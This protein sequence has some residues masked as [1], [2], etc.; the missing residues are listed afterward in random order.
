[1]GFNS[2]FK[3]LNVTLPIYTTFPSLS[4]HKP[5][6]LVINNAASYS[7]YPFLPRHGYQLFQEIFC[8]FLYTL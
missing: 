6:E 3:G 7:E 8:Q 1:M 5:R 4:V 2:G